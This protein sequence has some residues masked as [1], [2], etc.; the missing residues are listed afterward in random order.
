MVQSFFAGPF[1]GKKTSTIILSKDELVVREYSTKE[2]WKYGLYQQ[3]GF[4]NQPFSEILNKEIDQN[5]IHE[6]LN[7]STFVKYPLSEIEKIK[8]IHSAMRNKISIKL[9]NGSESKFSIYNRG[10]TDLY[11][12]L[13]LTNYPELAVEINKPETLIQKA[14]KY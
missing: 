8:L 1:I 2:S 12:D 11:F 14:L 3:L 7:S 6:I 13:F 5:S 4:P 10:K 9:K